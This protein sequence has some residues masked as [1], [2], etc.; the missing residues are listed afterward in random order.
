MSLRKEHAKEI[1]AIEEAEQQIRSSAYALANQLGEVYQKHGRNIGK[2][3]SE[4]IMEYLKEKVDYWKSKEGY[5]EEL[6]KKGI[7]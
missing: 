1:Q 3:I 5:R 7:K 6:A 4:G 2:V